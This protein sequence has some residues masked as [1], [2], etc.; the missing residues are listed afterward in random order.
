[1][2]GTEKQLF[3]KFNSDDGRSPH[4]LVALSPPQNGYGGY[5]LSPQTSTLQ[6]QQHVYGRSWSSGRSSDDDDL[7]LCDTISRKTL[8]YLIS[9]L[10]S[11]FPDYTFSDAKS[12]EFN[13]EPSLSVSWSTAVRAR[14]AVTCPPC[15]TWS[16]TSTASCPSR[17]PSATPRSTTP[18][19]SS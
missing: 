18:C 3:K 11:A 4:T 17:P 14:S 13:K 2:I 9:T 8:F 1:M 7:T 5:G 10:N 16:A 15:S 6:Q 12:S 19:G